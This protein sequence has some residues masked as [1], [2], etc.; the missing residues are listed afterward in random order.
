MKVVRADRDAT[1]VLKAG[2]ATVATWIGV[3]A[4]QTFS[5]SFKVGLGVTKSYSFSLV[6]ADPATGER[7]EAKEEGSV[8]GR[9]AV[10]WLDVR[11]DRSAYDSWPFAGSGGRDPADGGT[12]TRTTVT[13]N[14]AFA[15]DGGNRRLEL[16]T[17]SSD[18]VAYAASAASHARY[19]VLVRGR[20]QFVS[21][22]GA[23]EAPTDSPLAGLALGD[24]GGG[25]SLYGWT[26]DG[27]VRLAGADVAENEWTDWNAAID[28]SASPVT[29]TYGIGGA[30][31]SNAVTGA[32]ALPVAGSPT[33]LRTVRYVGSGAVDDF[34]GV[35]YE[36]VTIVAIREP[37]YA[38]ATS[39]TSPIAFR[40]QGGTKYLDLSISV[41]G[42]PSGTQYT[43]FV[44]RTLDPDDSHWIA[45]A[46]SRTASGT[47]IASGA[48]KLSV[49]ATADTQFVKIVA[50]DH[51]ISKGTKL[52]D[53]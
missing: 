13:N 51:S 29:V 6:H 21:E 9:K 7:Y 45:A 18:Y 53:L 23:P 52:S 30:V 49:P 31:L 43:A 19:A 25:V 47:E 32:T 27:W 46:A 36:P 1:L 41:E 8:L 10:G 40:T 4:G 42:Q 11:F 16:E 50:S 48:V 24:E 2:S 26:R 28:F 3:E 39:T 17:G 33:S 44:C 34:R 22:P 35:Y 37:E 12:W 20:A 15:T 14:T 5:A 38:A